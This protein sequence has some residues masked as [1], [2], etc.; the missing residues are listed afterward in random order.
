MVICFI[1][2]CLHI[3][4][5]DWSGQRMGLNNSWKIYSWCNNR[6]SFP[7]KGFYYVFMVHPINRIVMLHR[8]IASVTEWDMGQAQFLI[9][10]LKPLEAS[11]EPLNAAQPSISN[12]LANTEALLA[13]IEALL[14]NIEATKSL[15]GFQLSLTNLTA[16]T[17]TM[18]NKQHRNSLSVTNKENISNKSGHSQ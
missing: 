9:Y 1:L 18:I 12:L 10:F 6:E 4:I 14:A 15:N 7:L 5:A 16:N 13:N 2:A 3:H 17:E 11:T 8:V